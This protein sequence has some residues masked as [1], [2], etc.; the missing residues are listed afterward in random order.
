MEN[1]EV[2]VKTL[3]DIIKGKEVTYHC[4]KCMMNYTFPSTQNKGFECPFCH[5]QLVA[6]KYK[7]EINDV[8]DES[9]KYLFMHRDADGKLIRIEHVDK[10]EYEKR[11]SMKAESEENNKKISAA[12]KSIKEVQFCDI[13]P[14]NNMAIN[15]NEIVIVVYKLSQFCG[16]TNIV[17]RILKSVEDKTTEK[18]FELPFTFKFAISIKNDNSYSDKESKIYPQIFMFYKGKK[19]YMLEELKTTEFNAESVFGRLLYWKAIIENEF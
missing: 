6:G 7:S 3:D 9:K 15:E 10:E 11:M 18:E 8:E 13:S 19:E 5:S 14:L 16:I 17:E 12:L 4:E 2:K 1:I